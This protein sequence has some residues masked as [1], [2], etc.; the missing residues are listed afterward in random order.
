MFQE[1][2]VIV[3]GGGHAGSEAAAAAH[4]ACWHARHAR[5]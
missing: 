2:D 5:T 4:E 1:Y 3:V